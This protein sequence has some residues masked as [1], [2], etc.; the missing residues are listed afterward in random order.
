MRMFKERRI[1]MDAFSNE[2][3]LYGGILLSLISLFLG[4]I[5]AVVYCIGKHKLNIKFNSEY[6]EVPK[7]K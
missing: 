7:K 6:G 3:I 2:M 5:Y 1:I 4:V